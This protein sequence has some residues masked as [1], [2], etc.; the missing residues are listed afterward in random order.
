MRRSGQRTMW[1]RTTHPRQIVAYFRTRALTHSPLSEWG[2]AKLKVIHVRVSGAVLT[3]KQKWQQWLKHI[4]A[5]YSLKQYPW[6][7]YISNATAKNW[8]NHYIIN[9][10]NE[11]IINVDPKYAPEAVTTNA[12]GFDKDG[13]VLFLFLK[14]VIDKRAQTRA[15]T[16][17]EKMKFRSCDRSNRPE[18]KNAIKFNGHEN[19]IAEEL[20]VGW[21]ARAFICESTIRR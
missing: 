12:I 8:R 4:T 9:G 16:G 19:P 2:M 17:L 18:L 5:K 15:L 20:N 14:N 6:K 3:P 10:Q 11:H 13:N 21:Q 7:P 1:K